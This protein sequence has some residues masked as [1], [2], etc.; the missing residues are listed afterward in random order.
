MKGNVRAFL[1]RCRQCEKVE[2]TN[3][4]SYEY[5][6]Q[7]LARST[8]CDFKSSEIWQFLFHSFSSSHDA[9]C[10]RKVALCYIQNLI[11]VTNPVFFL[12]VGDG[13]IHGVQIPLAPVQT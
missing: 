2:I 1:R 3:S 12:I 6:K 5:N 10:S 4:S 9:F 11:F 8:T 7:K 13:E